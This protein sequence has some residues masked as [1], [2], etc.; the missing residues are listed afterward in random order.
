MKKQFTQIFMIALMAIP[1]L[2]SCAKYP[3]GPNFSLRTKEAR[4]TQKWNAISIGSEVLNGYYHVE[5]D[6][7]K[8]GSFIVTDISTEPGWEYEDAYSGTWQFN[9]NK[10]EL[11]IIIDGYVTTAKINRLTAKELWIDIDGDVYKLEAVE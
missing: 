7:N 1:F 3:D 10:E 5:F 4:L 2:N 9:N 8:N 6:F 11:Q